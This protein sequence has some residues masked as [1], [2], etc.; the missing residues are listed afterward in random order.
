MLL[1]VYMAIHLYKTL[2]PSWD[3]NE[4]VLDLG[5]AG[6]VPNLSIVKPGGLPGLSL[7]RGHCPDLWPLTYLA[8]VTNKLGH[9]PHTLSHLPN[10]G[11]DSKKEKDQAG[12]WCSVA[13]NGSCVHSSRNALEHCT[14]TVSWFHEVPTHGHFK[15][16][17]LTTFNF[18]QL[19]FSKAAP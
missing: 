12:L 2:I 16:L 17:P 14:F 19:Y 6:H 5:H 9:S 7:S 13:S 15:C 11:G 10:K 4:P 1:A 3:P 18:V 8:E